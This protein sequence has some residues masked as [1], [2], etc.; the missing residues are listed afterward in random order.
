MT[1]VLTVLNNGRNDASFVSMVVTLVNF[2]EFSQQIFAKTF[3]VYPIK[4]VENST[5]SADSILDE[6]QYATEKSQ[7]RRNSN[8]GNVFAKRFFNVDRI[9]ANFTKP[10]DFINY[11]HGL[12]LLGKRWVAVLGLENK[13]L[14]L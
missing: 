5:K 7:F 2:E 1:L 11:K 4:S 12:D 6:L 10:Y 9:H 13:N 3:H 14:N 8:F